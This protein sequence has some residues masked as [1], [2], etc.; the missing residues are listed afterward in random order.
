MTGWWRDASWKWFLRCE[1]MG[2]VYQ[3]GL[4]GDEPPSCLWQPFSARD[5]AIRVGPERWLC[6]RHLCQHISLISSA[7]A[8]LDQ[9]RRSKK[10]GA[11]VAPAA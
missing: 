2:D 4:P 3:T 9:R 1:L 6:Y 5:G 7:P 10:S 8:S 11:T